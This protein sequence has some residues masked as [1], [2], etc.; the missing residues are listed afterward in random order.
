MPRQKYNLYAV[1]FYIAFFRLTL[2]EP[3]SS[4]RYIKPQ[5]GLLT[6]AQFAQMIRSC[7]ILDAYQFLNFTF[8]KEQV[9]N[10]IQPCLEKLLD[11]EYVQ[12]PIPN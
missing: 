3:T 10:V 2:P 11:Q 5:Q 12:V 6:F 4:H 7:T 1:L 9:T 8:R